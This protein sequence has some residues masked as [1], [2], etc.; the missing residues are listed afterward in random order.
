M[1]QDEPLSAEA[2]EDMANA[3]KSYYNWL[4]LD[5]KE[6]V[7]DLA[8]AKMRREFQ[9]FRITMKDHMKLKSLDVSKA[10]PGPKRARVS[11]N[12]TITLDEEMDSPEE[13]VDL[14]SWPVKFRLAVTSWAVAGCYDVSV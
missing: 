11:H 9:A 1:F 4:A 5:P 14:H 2:Y 7:G 12:V 3:F 10:E 6:I 8:M 13:S